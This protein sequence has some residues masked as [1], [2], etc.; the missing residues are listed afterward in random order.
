MAASLIPEIESVKLAVSNQKQSLL[1]A[2]GRRFVTCHYPSHANMGVL[3]GV[4]V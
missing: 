4:A 1:E 2:S 3:G